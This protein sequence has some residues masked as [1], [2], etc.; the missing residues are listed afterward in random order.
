MRDVSK[1][2]GSTDKTELVETH[3]IALALQRLN[4]APYDSGRWKRALYHALAMVD[5]AG[6]SSLEKIRQA[7]ELP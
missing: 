3:N 1:R 4:N 7:I 6:R 2:Q 5:C